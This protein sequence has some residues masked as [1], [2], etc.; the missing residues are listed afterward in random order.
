M[1]KT[2]EASTSAPAYPEA[3]VVPE[4]LTGGHKIYRCRRL[5]YIE[6]HQARMPAL[7]TAYMQHDSCYGSGLLMKHFDPKLQKTYVT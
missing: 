1:M 5:R 7:E 4:R 2:K 3:S 6:H